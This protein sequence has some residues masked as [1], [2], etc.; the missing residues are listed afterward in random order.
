VHLHTDEPDQAVGLFVAAGEVSRLD[1]ADMREQVADRT[2]RLSAQRETSPSAACAVVAVANGDGL[3]G[4]YR[5]LGAHVIDGGATM[6]PSTYDLLAAIHAAGAP[7]AI[8][9]PN[10][11]NVILAAERAAE[12]SEVP[13]R[14][15]PTRSQQEGLLAL[16]AFDPQSPAEKNCRAVADAA[17]VLRTGGVARAAKADAQ[18]R[19][20]V[21]DAVGYAGDD[22]VAWGDP[23]ATLADVL[24]QIGDDA[25]VV[26]VIVGEGAPLDEAAFAP[27]VPDGAELELHYGGQAAWWYLVAAE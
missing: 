27:L 20:G 24:L 19:F 15:V 3:T 16:V 11:P 9:L 10:S 6:N 25:E 12:L 8:V 23:Q 7:E 2:A 5:E 18:G 13:A 1:V 21:G 26:T 4:M 17:A 14:V 22:L